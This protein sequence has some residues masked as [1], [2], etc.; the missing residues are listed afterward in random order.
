M[1]DYKLELI[2]QYC[3]TTGIRLRDYE[4]DLLYKVLENSGRYNGFE[5]SIFEARDS[6]RD[7]RDTWSN[8]EKRQYKIAIDYGRLH[9]YERYYLSV[10][11][12]YTNDRWN[13]SDAEDITDTRLILKCLQ[14]MEGD[15]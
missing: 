4:K 8:Y 10:S 7:Y 12:G 6:G 14:E 1:S 5:S 13:W 3:D 15:L 9:I 11:D 2:R